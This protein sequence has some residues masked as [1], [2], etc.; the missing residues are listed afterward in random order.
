MFHDDWEMVSRDDD[1]VSDSWEIAEYPRSPSVSVSASE[2]LVDLDARGTA[3][4]RPC[5]EARHRE[6]VAA[7]VARQSRAVANR[8]A[9]QYLF[10][11][12]AHLMELDAQLRMQNPAGYTKPRNGKQFQ[13]LPRNR[14]AKVCSFQI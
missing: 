2:V 5:D 11:N 12:A 3:R 6:L 1:E 13:K 8:T 10:G 14:T 9:E 4:A 7:D